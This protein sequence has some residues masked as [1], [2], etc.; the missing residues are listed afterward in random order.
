MTVTQR[1]PPSRH[2][3]SDLPGSRWRCRPSTPT[4]LPFPINP[5]SSL[6]RKASSNT[7]DSPPQKRSSQQREL[8]VE[9]LL[10]P[11][12]SNNMKCSAKRYFYLKAHIKDL[13]NN[14]RRGHGPRPPDIIALQDVPPQVQLS[15]I[16]GYRLEC[17]S[18]KELAPHHTAYLN[19]FEK[20]ITQAEKRGLKLAAKELALAMERANERNLASRRAYGSTDDEL[21]RQTRQHCHAIR[22]VIGMDHVAFFIRMSIPPGDCVF[23]RS[24]QYPGLITTL[25]LTTLSGVYHFHN[26]YNH[27]SIMEPKFLE[28]QYMS[29][30][31][32][33]FLADTNL[34]AEFWGG[35]NVRNVSPKGRTLG[36]LAMKA[37]YNPL[38]KGT[39]TYARGMRSDDRT[40]KYRTAVD[41][42]WVSQEIMTRAI[43]CSMVDARGLETDH[44]ILRLELD[45]QPNRLAARVRYNPGLADKEELERFA[46]EELAKINM[47]EEL[48]P[49]MIPDMVQQMT[50]ALVA[51]RKTC[52]PEIVPPR[53]VRKEPEA[54]RRIKRTESDALEQ[55]RK[56]PTKRTKR[57]FEKRRKE[58][59]KLIKKLD[60]DSFRRRVTISTTKDHYAHFKWA[61]RAEKWTRPTQSHFPTLKEGEVEH[62]T[63][64]AKADCYARSIWPDVCL[65]TKGSVGASPRLPDL[66]PDRHQWPCSQDVTEKEVLKILK[67]LPG[68]KTIGPDEV[69]IDVLN[70]SR[71][72][73]APYFTRLF[74][75]MFRY[76]THEADWK[77]GY[78]Y[79]KPKPGKE[80]YSQ[81]TSHRPLA[82]LSH[83]GKVFEKLIANRLK[84]I[85]VEN[86]LLPDEQFGAPGG[87][88]VKALQYLLNSVYLGWSYGDPGNN[89]K[90]QFS[91]ES[92]L[93]GLD[94][95]G[96]YD[97]VDR[98]KLLQ[99][100]ANYGIPDW[101]IRLVAS[102][103][104]ERSTI[105]DFHGDRSETY[106]VNI[107]IPQGSPVSP[108]LFLFFTAPLFKS[109]KVKFPGCT[110]TK[111]AYVDDT[112][113]L[114]TSNSFKKN[115][116]ILVTLH[117]ELM[118][119]A[120]PNGIHFSPH[121][122]KVLHFQRPH[123]KL[124]TTL[125][126]IPG[127][128]K[129]PR[130]VLV[131]DEDPLRILGVIVD[132][133][134]TWKSHVQH[135]IEKAERKMHDLQ[136]TFGRA[137]GP[138]LSRI[139]ALYNT[140]VLPR[141]TYACGA[142]YMQ[143]F[144]GKSQRHFRESN[145]QAL[146]IF[147]YQS[148]VRISGALNG[149]ST[150][151]LLK[152]I[153]IDPIEV[154]LQRYA[155]A[156]RPIAL[157]DPTTVVSQKL[158][159]DLKRRSQHLCLEL[160]PHHVLQLAAVRFRDGAWDSAKK[161]RS[162]E[163]AL[164]RWAEPRLRMRD[165]KNFAKK[166]AK[167][168]S[169]QFWEKYCRNRFG[170]GKRAVPAL[171]RQSGCEWGLA[172]L[173][174]HD[175]LSRAQSSILINI[176]TGAIGLN[177]YLYSIGAS[178]INDRRCP[179]CKQ[180]SHTA[181]HL[182]FK[183]RK[184][185]KPRRKLYK[186]LG[187][188]KMSALVTKHVHIA[189]EWAL[190]FFN[191]DY[192]AVYEADFQRE[193]AKQHPHGS[194]EEGD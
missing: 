11:I 107:G 31:A 161:I 35:E 75:A 5:K 144:E 143:G 129:D 95:K 165:I 72:A 162:Q 2:R 21:H 68:R 45:M 80:D 183:C 85:A 79:V 150:A 70:L 154:T 184:L 174:R 20:G 1:L 28:A 187:D 43:N 180:G 121:K 73:S 188:F 61:R 131:T 125:P 60:R 133:R 76:P 177:D 52:I 193:R 88:T 100:L 178:S 18:R 84:A 138:S 65:K 89:K 59:N 145:L 63:K 157:D 136:R 82:I 33:V 194:L 163:E 110:V 66:K 181:E 94:I 10:S 34:H 16:P 124:F 32:D 93:L 62:K 36:Q 41:V 132:P 9:D 83:F 56:S 91:R 113:L 30:K 47:P 147:H 15:G 40:F 168:Q 42:A 74:L 14:F 123:T 182:F 191:I 86:K 160:H 135:V 148:L 159:E 137:W 140:T 156:Q 120:E 192:L 171:D 106:W 153:Y 23:E 169:Q 186:E 55:Y 13:T 37:M 97:H 39:V 127:L 53:K 3:A 90:S 115:N 111:L 81:P 49:S 48:T 190:R 134:L 112:Y 172:N 64:A 7:A 126:D 146:K 29:S 155:I 116:D 24:V 189:T 108:I 102:F 139:R 78:T 118:L 19:R 50:R 54:L 164:K 58:A 105:L 104:S 44:G 98:T 17:Y 119:W 57:Y 67:D 12:Y 6:K 142:W 149:T 152:E 8:R 128:G 109:F 166:Q 46:A 175:G 151:M 77:L 170:R 51:I 69:D 179:L 27:M 25:H 4:P 130:S 185:D 141:I 87:D 158:R 103:L 176:R 96:A 167:I 71:R 26:I 99:V 101:L 92:T 173:S 114:V 122:Y 117:R 38:K 22:D